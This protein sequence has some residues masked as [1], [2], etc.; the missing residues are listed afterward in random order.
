MEGALAVLNA[1]KCDIWI[2]PHEQTT[3]PLVESFMK[4]K[5]MMT[6][7]L[8][9]LAELLDAETTEPFPF[10]KTFEEAELEPFI[11]THT[12]GTT[13]VPKPI[14]WTHGLISTLDTVRLLPPA[15]EDHGLPPWTN[16][17]NEGDTIYSSFP[18]SHVSNLS[19]IPLPPIFN[20]N[21]TIKNEC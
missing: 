12:S 3:P 11:I 5:P 19:S 21:I 15:N 17:W 1:A 9:G 6:L 20:C 18:M 4:Q 14:S 8:P 13:G 2:K 10:Q 16:N 7:E